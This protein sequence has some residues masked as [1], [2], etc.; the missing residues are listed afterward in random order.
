MRFFTDLSELYS[1]SLSPSVATIG[2]FDGVHCGHKFLIHQVC[3]AARVRR[4][5]SLLITF[6]SHPRMVMQTDYQPRLLSSFD[7]KCALLSQTEADSCVALPF[8]YELASLSARDF[9]RLI[10]RDR[11]QVRTLVIG[12]DHRFGHNRSEGFADYVRYGNELGIEVLQAE[13]LVMSD[14]HVSSSVVRVFLSEGKFD[15]AARCLG[16]NY[17]LNGRVT[18]GKQIGRTLGFPTAN[19][20]VNDALKLIPTDGVYAVRVCVEDYIY[21]GILNIGYRPTIDDDTHRTI[22][23]H[24]LHFNGNLYDK[25][26]RIEFIHHIRGEQKFQNREALIHQLQMDAEACERI[27][28]QITIQD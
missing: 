4:L 5:S 19:I 11:L 23:V 28:E 20:E 26:L 17:F 8:T 1:T 21:K 10:L 14:I 2:F 22:E 3:E 9:M 15:L 6:P 27:F 12:Y 24:L 16:Y 18:N 13:A 25:H 7:E